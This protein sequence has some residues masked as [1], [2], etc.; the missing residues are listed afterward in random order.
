MFMIFDF[1]EI[2]VLK[3]ELVLIFYFFCVKTKKEL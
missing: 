3:N 2:F 1:Y